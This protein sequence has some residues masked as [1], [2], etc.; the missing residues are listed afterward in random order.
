MPD[1][2]LLQITVKSRVPFYFS[3]VPYKYRVQ[4]RYILVN[5]AIRKKFRGINIENEKRKKTFQTIMR[6]HKTDRSMGVSVYIARIP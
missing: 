1:A 4:N 5:L 6:E 2:K 3:K